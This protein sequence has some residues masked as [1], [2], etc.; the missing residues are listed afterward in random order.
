MIDKLMA[1]ASDFLAEIISLELPPPCDRLNIP[2]ISTEDKIFAEDAHKTS[3][4]EFIENN[5]TYAPGY[6]VT[7]AELRRA[8][9]DVIEPDET[10]VWTSRRISKELPL[11]FIKGRDPQTNDVIVGNIILESNATFETR[12]PCFVKN[13]KLYKGDD[14]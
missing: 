10:R 2:C 9:W 8:L 14:L 1:E 13:G 5:C 3:L 6:I 11:P 4:E 7:L 12:K